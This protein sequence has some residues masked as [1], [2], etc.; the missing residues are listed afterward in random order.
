MSFGAFVSW[1]IGTAAGAIL[2]VLQELG[3]HFGWGWVENVNQKTLAF[4]LALLGAG[5]AALFEVVLGVDLFSDVAGLQEIVMI[6]G[7]ILFGGQ[8]MYT[9]VLRK[10]K[11]EE[12]GGPASLA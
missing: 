7:S 2:S 12:I 11:E 4:V 3:Q 10:K 8:A 1:L 5:I 6:V 9:M